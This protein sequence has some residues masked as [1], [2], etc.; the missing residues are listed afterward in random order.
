MPK[1]HDAPEQGAEHT[2]GGQWDWDA[3][4]A[5]LADCAYGWAPELFPHGRIV[6]GVLRCANIDGASPHGD[7]SCVIELKGDKAGCWSTILPTRAA[8]RAVP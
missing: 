8:G 2:S 4:S 3:M 5:A 6:E 7:G 1:F